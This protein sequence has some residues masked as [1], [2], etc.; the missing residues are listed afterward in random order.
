MIPSW[1]ISA[2]CQSKRGFCLSMCLAANTPARRQNCPQSLKAS[3][4]KLPGAQFARPKC[5]TERKMNLRTKPAHLLNR[6]RRSRRRLLMPSPKMIL[7][8]LL[9]HKEAKLLLP[10]PQ[11]RLKPRR[12]LMRRMTRSSQMHLVGSC[13]KTGALDRLRL[14]Q[15]Q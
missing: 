15:L 11:R 7:S 8:P 14:P 1:P 13:R 9:P 6:P 4:L 2:Y 5:H 3:A 10:A 12:R